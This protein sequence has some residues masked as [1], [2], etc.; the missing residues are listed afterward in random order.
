[1]TRP[2]RVQDMY[3]GEVLLEGTLDRVICGSWYAGC[4]KPHHRTVWLTINGQSHS[5]KAL[6]SDC[7]DKEY[8]YHIWTNRY[9]M[10]KEQCHAIK[11]L[12]ERKSL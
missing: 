8:E 11:V 10:I 3:T 2:V 7:N 1:M 12:N 6:A 5:L 9:S 4:C